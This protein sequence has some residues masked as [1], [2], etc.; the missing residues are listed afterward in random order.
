MFAL[1]ICVSLY[2]LVLSSAFRERNKNEVKYSCGEC[3]CGL[4]EHTLSIRVLIFCMRSTR[5]MCLHHNVNN[6]NLIP[7]S[8]FSF[9]FFLSL[10]SPS[11]PLSFAFG[12]V[13]CHGVEQSTSATTEEVRKFVTAHTC[14]K[15]VKL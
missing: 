11:T 14:I 2:L 6:T 7:I 10:F 5:E 13:C 15:N 9:Y 12:V 4:N 3:T 8:L 1:C